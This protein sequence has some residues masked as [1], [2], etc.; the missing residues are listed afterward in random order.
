[1]GVFTSDTTFFRSIGIT[2]GVAVFGNVVNNSFSS[3]YAAHLPDQLKSSPQFGAFLSN[4][5]PQALISPDTIK[6]LQAQLQSLGLPAAQIQ[7]TLAAIQ[8]PIKPA[9]GAATTS[10]FLMG[11]VVLAL[12]V[13]LVVF[14]PE[15]A[16]RRR[17]SRQAAN[18]EVTAVEGTTEAFSPEP[19]GVAAR[20]E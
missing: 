15:I 1:L 12:S 5:S 8:A 17:A 11:A 4:L 6:A 16:L 7:Q 3:E 20:R 2:V 19:A 10:A 18:V 9:L 14:I 13:G